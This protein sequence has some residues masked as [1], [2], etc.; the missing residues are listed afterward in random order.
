M[1]RSGYIC[2]FLLFIIALP[3][4]LAAD[5]PDVYDISLVTIGP[6]DPV[7]SWWGHIALMV[8]HRRSG[9]SYYF[10]YGNFS[11]QEEDFLKKF[12]MGR[13]TFRKAVS[14]GA[15]QL[16]RAVAQNR[17]VTIQGLNL[18]PAAENRLVRFL[19]QEVQPGN[20]TYLYDHYEDNCATRIRDILDEAVGGALAEAASEPIPFTYRDLFRRYTDGS[21]PLDWV[22]NFAQ[23]R[24]IDQ[25]LTAWDAMFL[26]QE[27][28]RQVADLHYTDGK[29]RSVPL[30]RE[31]RLHYEPQGRTPAAAEA[32]AG[33]RLWGAVGGLLALLLGMGIWRGGPRLYGALSALFALIPA[34]FGTLLFFMSF[35][36]DHSS[37]WNNINLVWINP[38]WWGSVAAG[39]AV[40]FDKKG[41]Q[42][43]RRILTRFWHLFSI[44]GL[45]LIPLSA[46][47]PFSQQSAPVI[48]LL[49]PGVL[50]LG[51]IKSRFLAKKAVP[52]G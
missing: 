26:P 21:P 24:G 9:Q 27:V 7:Y 16:E 19:Q 29:G 42:K 8:D 39:M 17:R 34:L 43:R 45:L 48:L 2:F 28:K 49:L 52:A 50:V 5:E 25:A 36:T 40:F 41:K 18:S 30:V 31:T 32:P 22:L 47:G 10:D 1:R 35:F 33:Y 12:L 15:L 46:V 4:G 20:A 37:T 38:L 44:T 14:P 23:G 6:G 3:V 13:L 11:F 51:F